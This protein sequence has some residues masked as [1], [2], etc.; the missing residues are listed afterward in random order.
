M[1]YFR[2][3][4]KRGAPKTKGSDLPKLTVYEKF[5]ISFASQI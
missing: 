1:A 3:Y 2:H 5:L 4:K